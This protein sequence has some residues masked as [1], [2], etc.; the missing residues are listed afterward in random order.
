MVRRGVARGALEQA[1]DLTELAG[2]L[3]DHLHG[4][5]T[6]GLH[7]HGSEPVRKH[8]AH[9][10]GS[11]SDR[12]EDVDTVGK[13][14]VLGILGT[15][16]LVDGMGLDTG[17]E[18][19]EKGKRHKGGRANGETLADSGGGVTGSVK[20]VSLLADLGGEARHLGDTAGVVANGA[21]HID[22]KAGSKVGKHAKSGEGNAVHAAELE[23]DED[24]DGEDGDGDDGRLVA[25][26]KTVDDV[27]GG[28]SLG[29]AG[30]LTGGLVA[31]GGEVLGDEA[32]D[33][34]TPEAGSDAEEDLGVVAVDA[35]GLEGARDEALLDDE[36]R[37]EEGLDDGV[38]DGGKKDGGDADLGLEDIFDV[39]LGLDGLDVSGD[40]RRDE[41]DEDTG[42]GNDEGEGEGAPSLVDDGDGVGA[43]DEGGAGGLGEGAEEIRAHTGDVT[44]VVTDVVGNGGGVARVILGDVLN[45]LAGKIGADVGSLGVDT[46]TDAAEHG[47]GGTTETVAGHGLEELDGVVVLLDLV[48]G[49]VVE[50]EEEAEAVAHEE[51]KAAEAEAHDAASA[52]GGVEGAGPAVGGVARGDGGAGVGK[53]GDAHADEAGKDGGGATDGE[54]SGGEG[55]DAPVEGVGGVGD[56]DEDDEAKDDDEGE[57]DAVLGKEEGIGTLADGLVD[58]NKSL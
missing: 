39:G 38:Q 10:K 49:V 18:G 50:G 42:G 44:D 12:L 52:E 19:A 15:L 24:V 8:G 32:D 21:V 48:G 14:D 20:S 37:G 41:A 9:D 1:G 40:E 5:G 30:D 58:G 31:V 17:D 23:G 2:D 34:A 26:G 35:N 54:G 3:L 46:A 13:R 22:G 57:A 47:N 16:G 53:D 51:G 55:A 4:G 7:G 28:A 43:D 56:E 6:D 27:G 11:E 36:M 29:G 33:A 45:N 25:K